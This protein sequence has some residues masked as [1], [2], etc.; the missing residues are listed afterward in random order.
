LRFFFRFL[1]LDLRAFVPS[2]EK[3]PIPLY[4]R[5]VV[6]LGHG[7]ALRQETGSACSFPEAVIGQK[8]SFDFPEFLIS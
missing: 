2:C 3:N 1:L 4:C 7:Y 8:Y 6:V 5:L